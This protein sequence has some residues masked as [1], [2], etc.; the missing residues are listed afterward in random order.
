MWL[1]G[2]MAGAGVQ[3]VAETGNNSVLS[4]ELY[5]AMGKRKVNEIF[6]ASGPQNASAHGED[7]RLMFTPTH[8]YGSFVSMIFPSPD[9]FI[10]AYNQDMC[11]TDTGKWIKSRVMNLYAWD[12]GTDSGK[13]FTADDS[14][15]D[16]KGRIHLLMPGMDMYSSFNPGF[17][18]IPRF[19]TITFTLDHVDYEKMECEAHSE[20]TYHVRFQGMWTMASHPRTEMPDGAGFSPIVVASHNDMYTM[21]K[22]GGTASPGVEKVAE[23]GPPDVLLDEL[24][25]KQWYSVYDVE[26]ASAPLAVNA[27]ID[28]Y[29]DV[30]KEFPYISAI[31]MLFPSPDWFV[32]ISSINLCDGCFWE[33]HAVT[34]SLQPWDAGTEDGTEFN[35]TNPATDPQGTM[36]IIT[37][38]QMEGGVLGAFYN[39]ARQNIQRL[40]TITIERKSGESPPV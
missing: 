3:Q 5:M 12:A 6:K 27:T 19:A 26:S 22:P 33:D 1:P 32:G 2:E 30:K 21:W 31:A 28:F 34:L 10:G 35:T 24:N 38:D 25:A 37:R 9:W 4:N 7:F 39:R 18:K 14:P 29:V 11:G 40:G 23:Q 13:N 16:P 20:E 8:H 15:T 36:S 17:D